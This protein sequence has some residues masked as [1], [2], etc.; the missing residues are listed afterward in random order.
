MSRKHR[1]A[2]HLGPALDIA[3]ERA[4][5]WARGQGR[6]AVDPMQ[7]RLHQGSLAPRADAKPMGADSPLAIGDATFSVGKIQLKL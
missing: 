1:H 3:T 2:D 5:G 6:M 7:F 4:G